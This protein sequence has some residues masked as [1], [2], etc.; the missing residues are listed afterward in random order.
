MLSSMSTWV[1]VE[2]LL[3]LFEITAEDLPREDRPLSDELR[4]K[5]QAVAERM[6]VYASLKS[7]RRPREIQ[8]DEV[9]DQV[10]QFERL[11]G[12]MSGLAGEQVGA[13]DAV[14]C[15]YFVVRRERGQQ[16][17]ELADLDPWLNDGGARF[18][19]QRCEWHS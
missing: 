3:R 18:V 5:I 6:P 7:V 10:T 11:W 17:K 8:R 1:D 16:L 12:D 13:L 14:K 15:G 2:Q 4:S 19:G 9:V